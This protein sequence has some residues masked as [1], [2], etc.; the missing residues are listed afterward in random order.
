MKNLLKQAAI[1]GGLEAISRLRLGGLFPAAA[2]RGLIFTLHHVRPKVP[3]R[4]EPNG[5]LEVTPDFLKDVIEECL[6]AGLTPI[7][8]E[9]LPERLADKADTRRYVA[10]TLDDGYRNNRDFAA[11]L[12]RAYSIPY[13]IFVTPGFVERRTPMWWETLATL[14][15]RDESVEL[16]L[17]TG[18]EHHDITRLADRI[19][20]FDTV[21]IQVNRGDQDEA[22]ERL[23]R[24]ARLAGIEPLDIIER[25]VMDEA[26]L[27]ALAESDP[28][29]RYGGHTMTHPLLARTSAERLEAEITGSMAAA[30]QY[31]GR[32]A[33]S[34]AYPY[35][36]ACAI[37]E[38]EFTAAAK[39][40]ISI[41]VTTRPG[42]LTNETMSRP[43]AVQR[44][45]LN[46]L[47]QKRHYVRALISGLPFRLKA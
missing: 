7:A 24:A 2:G 4:F 13:T 36:T 26:E 31:G 38:R 14:L 29:V 8:L 18:M 43:M 12:F 6:A 10:F 44:V 45:S 16:D 20:L 23:N 27:K 21:C 17:G 3:M 9:D 15:N 40:G 30:S 11:P 46:G 42:V 41:A 28:L 39:A 35:G 47:Y 37:G 5:H 1:V 19:R 34:F 25:E 22:V 32:Q 33:T